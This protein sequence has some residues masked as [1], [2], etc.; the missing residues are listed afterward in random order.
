MVDRVQKVG[1]VYTGTGGQELIIRTRLFGA[2]PQ[3]PE[4]SKP[5]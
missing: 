3:A 2:K 1:A 5:N 4:G